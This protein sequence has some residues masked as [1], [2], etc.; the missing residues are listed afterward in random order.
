MDVVSSVQLVSMDPGGCANVADPS[1]ASAV[2]SCHPCDPPMTPAIPPL[3]T[4]ST[5]AF[6]LQPHAEYHVKEH[7]VDEGAPY[8]PDDRIRRTIAERILTGANAPVANTYVNRDGSVRLSL[9]EKLLATYCHAFG[10]CGGD[11]CGCNRLKRPH[12][13]QRFRELVATRTASALL[14][15]PVRAVTLGSGELLTDFEILLGLW[16]RGVAIESVV[17]IDTSY[18]ADKGSHLRALDALAVFFAPCRV[19]SC[20]SAEDYSTAVAMQPELYGRANLFI[21][22]DAA[23]VPYESFRQAAS[24]ALLDGSLAF[25]LANVN[26]GH[27]GQLAPLEKWLPSHLKS[28]E[29]GR[30]G[31]Y[32][33]MRILRK[34]GASPSASRFEHEPL[35]HDAG[36]GGMGAGGTGGGGMGG[37]SRCLRD[38]AAYWLATHSRE[39]AAQHGAR[40]F[41]VVYAP[42]M[43]VRAEP[44]RTAAIVG[45]RAVGDEVIAEEVS[46]DGWARLSRE[47]DTYAGY[48]H[49]DNCGKPMY[50]LIRADDVGEL[51]REVVLDE[52]GISI[53]DDGWL[54]DI[55]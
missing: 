28:G 31:S 35:P 42:R 9:V 2:A 22:C 26:R 21:Y 17:A 16:S 7:T 46:I 32:F 49:F 12:C 27:D 44:S 48:R 37:A 38:E 55:C 20:A 6:R 15:R 19:F 39:R 36:G 5:T 25:E 14:Q 43:P 8:V 41:K 52:K 45:V 24:A 34:A 40:L 4:A 53:D 18:K 13:R 51:M 3:A 23:A 50:M 33:S 47:L 1:R 10:E 54:P 30:D 11:G 29:A